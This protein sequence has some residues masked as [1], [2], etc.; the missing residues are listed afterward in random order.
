[1]EIILRDEQV[2]GYVRRA[3]YGFYVDQPIAYG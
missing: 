3:D 1:M 2:V